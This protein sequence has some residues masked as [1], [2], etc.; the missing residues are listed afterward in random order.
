MEQFRAY[1]LNITSIND[2]AMEDLLTLLEKRSFKKGE[3]FAEAGEHSKY[4]G[5]LLSG[6]MRGF[7]RTKL[8]LYI[9]RSTRI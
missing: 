6:I 4:S 1:L 2:A 7:F 5:F 9:L 3:F 8:F